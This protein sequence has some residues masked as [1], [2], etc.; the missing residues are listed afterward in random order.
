MFM[1]A[2]LCHVTCKT[3][4]R[5]NAELKLAYTNICL[6]VDELSGIYCLIHANMH[7][8]SCRICCNATQLLMDFCLHCVYTLNEMGKERK[9]MG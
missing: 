8:Y 9:V 7:T 5:K 4:E 1:C 3:K 2:C 6:L